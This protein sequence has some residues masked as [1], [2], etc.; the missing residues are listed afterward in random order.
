MYKLSISLATNNETLFN[1]EYT[2]DRHGMMSLHSD[3]ISFARQCK[4]PMKYSDMLLDKADKLVDHMNE[5]VR[6][7][8]YIINLS[9]TF[10]TK[11]INTD[12]KKVPTVKEIV[13]SVKKN[14][15]DKTEWH[16]RVY[17]DNCWFADVE[18]HPYGQVR[19]WVG[20]EDKRSGDC[21]SSLVI[22]NY[23]ND[24]GE[25]RYCTN[26]IL[27]KNIVWEKIQRV[28]KALIQENLL[29]I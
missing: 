14:I 19:F 26:G 29:T 1:R 27:I 8:N 17:E 12:N 25:L 11:V 2:E 21:R 15:T 18:V 6:I 16:S 22:I 13:K 3:I 4:I 10:N 20:Y 24:K 28:A 23:L 9:K 5:Q 7:N